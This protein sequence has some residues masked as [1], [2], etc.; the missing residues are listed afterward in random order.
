[1]L[2]N[3]AAGRVDARSEPGRKSPAGCVAILSSADA[4]GAPAQRPNENAIAA[5]NR[6]EPSFGV[7]LGDIIKTSPLLGTS[8]DVLCVDPRP[9]LSGRRL[10]SLPLRLG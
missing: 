9:L 1:M 4:P 6:N 5:A 7:F 3:V 2:K 8:A 10:G